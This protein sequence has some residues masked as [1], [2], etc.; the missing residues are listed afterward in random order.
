M[1]KTLMIL[2]LWGLWIILGTYPT[3]IMGQVSPAQ[4]QGKV[5]ALNE[6]GERV[7]LPFASVFW[8]GTTEG[9]TTDPNGKFRLAPVNG[10]SLLV[11]SFM[12]YKS[13]TIETNGYSGEINLILKPR[14]EALQGIEVKDRPG[15]QFVSKLTTIKTEHITTE[16]LKQLACCN[17]SESFENSITVDV[18]YTD[19]VSGA[20]QIQMLGLAGV[21]SQL[22]LENMPFLRS[23][24]APY[25]LSYVPGPWMQSIQVSKGTASVINGFES[26]TGQINLEYFKP[27]HWENT[28]YIN[29]FGSSEGR[30][31]V[32]FIGRIPV[33]DRLSTLLMAHGSTQ[34]SE[35]DQDKDGFMDL[36]RTRQ[37]N[38]FNRW[39][40]EYGDLGHSQLMVNYVSE[41][42]WGGSVGS[43]DNN[44]W[45]AQGLYASDIKN[46]RLQAFLKS[47]FRLDDHGHNS[48]GLQLSGTLH[49]IDAFFGDRPYNTTTRELYANLILQLE[50]G[51]TEQHKVSAGASFHW[52]NLRENFLF[53]SLHRNYRTPGVF[54]EYT[55]TPSPDF[56]VMAGIRADHSNIFGTFYTPRIHIRWQPFSSLVIRGS[57][58]RGYR[59]PTML[60]DYLSFL[61]SS[62]QIEIQGEPQIEK[63]WNYGLNLT[64][65]W[66]IGDDRNLDV[67]LDFYNT[68][69]NSQWVADAD[70]SARKVVLYNLAGPSKSHSYQAEIRAEPF[71]G[72]SVLTAFR[73][74]DVNM[75]L[76]N[77]LR[78][79][80][81]VNRYKALINLSQK[82]RF[83]KWQFDFTFLWNGD[84]RLPY[85]GDNPKTYRLA[86]RSPSYVIMH[87]QITRRFKHWE[88]Y[89]G[90]ENLGNYHQ[91]HPVV[92]ADDPYGPFFDASMVWGPLAGRMIYTGLR[93][94]IL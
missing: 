72:F 17:L 80:P 40:Y 2:S 86:E 60:N 10:A 66:E 25:G 59:M 79:K 11:A 15:N 64:Q 94:N 4:I 27:E 22:M 39:T 49:N 75:L 23:I 77:E 42:R 5:W 8:A 52:E 38:L 47:G 13:D 43:Y 57:A 93:W 48:I 71:K 32:N 34:Q 65:T 35:M 85:T 3:K 87:G 24:A 61:S 88:V 14:S 54:A 67:T 21:Y 68:S 73:Y 36:P 70:V 28:G 26:I 69:F 9:T 51:H 6:K 62:R 44:S 31:E 81:F 45:R 19:A 91:H 56:S 1:I 92:A 41:D 74:N 20:Q 78:E 90:S 63:A 7:P 84:A 82:T 18:G 37:I 29:V 12:G 30:G 83:D 58:G 50:P 46:Q 53:D 16:G 55:F 89:A 33:S 76:N